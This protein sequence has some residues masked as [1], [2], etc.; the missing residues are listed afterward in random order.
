MWTVTK[1]K[2]RRI[3]NFLHTVPEQA[4]VSH[5][6]TPT[7]YYF[8]V[9]SLVL[10][11]GDVKVIKWT[12]IWIYMCVCVQISVW[13]WQRGVCACGMV[14]TTSSVGLWTI[15]WVLNKNPGVVL[16]TISSH[17]SCFIV[18]N[19][20]QGGGP[21]FPANVCWVEVCQPVSCP[22]RWKSAVIATSVPP[23]C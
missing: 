7:L 16:S 3:R 21:E 1:S 12:W 5:H 6:Q 17:R 20:G 22:T 18:L 8:N 9:A 13:T 10:T 23:K 14:L 15:P 11:L 4:Q 2:S 19:V